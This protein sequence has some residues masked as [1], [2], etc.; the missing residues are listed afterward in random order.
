MTEKWPYP[1]SPGI[2][3]NPE[4]NGTHVL[5]QTASGE[6]RLHKWRAKTRSWSIGHLPSAMP[7]IFDYVGPLPNEDEDRKE[8]LVE[9]AISILKEKMEITLVETRSNW[10]AYELYMQEAKKMGHI[11]LVADAYGAEADNASILAQKKESEYLDLEEMIRVLR[12]S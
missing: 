9:K 6:L 1:E 8:E 3:M 12:S 10:D 4:K 2:P 7:L 11:K 5:R